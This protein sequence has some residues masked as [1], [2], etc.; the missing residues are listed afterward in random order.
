[1]Q[2][3]V[4]DAIAQRLRGG[5]ASLSSQRVAPSARQPPPAPPPIAATADDLFELIDVNHS[6]SIVQDEFISALVTPQD[7]DLTS[8]QPLSSG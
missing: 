3:Q 1:M 6:D 5:G 4:G 2:Q 8:Y 7:L